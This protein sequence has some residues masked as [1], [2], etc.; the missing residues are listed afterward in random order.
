[1]AK[2]TSRFSD[3]DIQRLKPSEKSFLESEP[4]GL[5]VRVLPSGRKSFMTV[6][7]FDGKQR[8]LT[9]GRYPDI[10]LK[11]ARKKLEEIR[12][13]IENEI[14][15]ALTK[16]IK[17][18]D[19]INAPTVAEFAEEYLEKWAIPKKK[20]AKE[21]K[22]ILEK[23]VIPVWG[24]RKLKDIT[25]REIISL[26][27][28]V[29]E[30]GTIMANRTLAVIRKMFNFALNR[31]V[32]ELSPCQNIT[33]PGKEV[34]KER[35]LS[36]DE[37]KALWPK[38]TEELTDQTNRAIKMILA[39][40]QRPNEVATM[41]WNEVD[42]EWWT[43]PKKK[44]KNSKVHRVFLNKI[45]LELIGEPQKKRFVFPSL[46]KTDQPIHPNAFGKAL[47]SKMGK[48]GIE[49]FSAHD[50]R[51]TAA[52]HIAELGH[53]IYV[54]KVLNHTDQSI[55]AIYDRYAYDKEK[56]IALSAWGRKLEG[57]IKPE[58]KNCKVINLR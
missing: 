49:Y 17:R 31:G 46:R 39:T 47:R 27:D 53:G 12:K 41:H 6:Y 56:K 23:D 48:F 50:L 36:E 57:L 34:E 8:W 11:K 52:T 55:T 42:G 38:M 4:N 18:A 20:S 13:N 7:S 16:R 19:Q 51:R 28:D 26:L 29:A 32:I 5:Y 3:R 21:D 2:R 14:D 33:P 9:I 15:P 40:G 44:T 10:T 43:I 30:R 45:A 58:G 24:K 22:R 1:M 37:V 54:G 35:F 25:R